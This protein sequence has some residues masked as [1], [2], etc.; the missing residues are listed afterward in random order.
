[1]G[2]FCLLAQ[3]EEIEKGPGELVGAASCA[4]NA[5]EAR[6]GTLPGANA[7][8]VDALVRPPSAPRLGQQLIPL[9]RE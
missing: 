9:R 3:S 8:R 6:L 4:D 5:A 1:M 2:S 7:P